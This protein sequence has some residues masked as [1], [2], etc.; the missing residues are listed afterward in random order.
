MLEPVSEFR[1]LLWPNN[2]PFY[3]STAFSLSIQQLID[4]WRLPVLNNVVMNVHV[5]VS[6]WLCVF[7]SLVCI[8]TSA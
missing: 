8:H 6:E 5:Q 7:A 4:I 3:G 2:I 1:F